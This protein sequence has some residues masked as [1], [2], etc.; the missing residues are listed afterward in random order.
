[1][2]I[3]EHEGMIQAITF[4]LVNYWNHEK[5]KKKLVTSNHLVLEE[6]D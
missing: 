2:P 1:M 3:H 4:A 6:K 5:K